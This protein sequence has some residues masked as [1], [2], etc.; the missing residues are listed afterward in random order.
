[1]TTNILDIVLRS[2][3]VFAVVLIGLR[4]LG[5][6]H[7]AQLSLVDLV[8]ILLISNAVQ[9]AMVGNDNSLLGGIIAAITLLVMSYFF[10]LILYRSRRA[11]HL[12]EGT[13]T[14]LIHNGKVIHKHLQQEK[15]TEDELERAVREHGVENIRH[16]KNAVMEA[17]GTISVIPMDGAEKHIDTFRHRRM[18]YQQ[19]RTL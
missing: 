19:K 8:L 6:R 2:A 17:D 16:V 13:P 4:L 5:K 12:F 3:V 15:I 18:K 14:L 1:M 7:V 10:T 9:N 11:E